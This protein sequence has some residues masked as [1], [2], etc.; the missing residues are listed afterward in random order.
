MPIELPDQLSPVEKRTLNSFFQLLGTNEPT[1]DDIWLCMDFVWDAQG[2]DNENID[3]H[4][5]C[6]FYNHPVWLLNGLFIEQHDESL[7]YRNIFSDWVARQNPQRIADFGG[8][9]GTLARIIA[10]KCP[11]VQVDVVEPHPHRY[12]LE[13]SKEYPNLVFKPELDGEYDLLLATDVFEHV[14]DPLLEIEGSSAHLKIGGQYLIANCFYPVIKCHLPCTFHFRYS[15]LYLLRRMNLE[16]GEQVAYG[17]VFKKTGFVTSSNV[18]MQ[19]RL[20]RV[21]YPVIKYLSVL[22][23]HVRKLVFFLFNKG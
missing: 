22:F 2:C 20:S 1:L 4:K 23:S 15:W 9:F 14:T 17:R 19:E 6:Q 3:D 18:R 13:L 5:L 11:Q 7:N 12:A 16:A 21:L 8:G 10:A